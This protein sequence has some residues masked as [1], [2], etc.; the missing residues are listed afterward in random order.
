MSIRA[1]LV[2]VETS[3]TPEQAVLLWFR[4]AQQTASYEEYAQKV[5]REP[6]SEAPRSRLP[7]M[8]A[9]AAREALRKQG[10]NEIL[11][12][13][14]EL[15]AWK[16][17]DF[18]LLL[19]MNLNAEAL[20]GQRER[21][22]CLALLQQQ[23]LRMAEDFDSGRPDKHNEWESWRQ[24]LVS[25]LRQHYR[26]QAAASLLGNRYFAGNAVLFQDSIGDLC[27]C[28]ELLEKLVAVYDQCEDLPC[29][30]AIDLGELRRAVEPQASGKASAAV[31]VARAKVLRDLGDHEAA[32]RL[33]KP[34]LGIPT[35][36]L[37]V[38]AVGRV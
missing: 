14:A 8:V 4:E 10:K 11:L 13:K 20:E 36:R 5:M 2:K 28:I 15:Q 35:N 38:V 26:F 19:I 12:Q 34:H 7:R 21:W 1:R 23:L 33:M 32:N 9:Q 29:W 16:Q 22:L 18:L 31:D 25:E 17:T 6:V 24:L 37:I 30:K 3:L 27:G